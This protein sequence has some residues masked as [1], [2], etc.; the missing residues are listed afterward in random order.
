VDETVAAKSVITEYQDNEAESPASMSSV[1]GRTFPLVSVIIPVYNGE[2]YLA[3]A[4]D[5]ALAQT[6]PCV[7]VIVINDGSTDTSPKILEHYGQ[8]I[9]VFHQPNSGQATARNVG[10]SM[11]RG[12]WIAFLDQD[13]LWDP[14]KLSQQMSAVQEGD[15]VVYST[16]RTIDPHGRIVRR[17][18]HPRNESSLLLSD[19]IWRNPPAPLTVLVRR[20][21]INAVGGFDAGNRFGTDDYQLWLGLVAT[22]H[23]FRYLRRE[24]ASYR[25]HDS[26]MSKNTPLM[27]QGKVYALGQTAARYPAAFGRREKKALKRR[28][29]DI[30]LQLGIWH[31]RRGS[32]SQAAAAFGQ[33]VAKQPWQ[34]QAWT[35]LLLSS[36]PLRSRLVPAL[37]RIVAL[38]RP[39][40]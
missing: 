20:E 22:G 27:C 8:N 13:D 33:V 15:T 17:G 3:Q 21:A 26:N 9:R 14:D 39:V 10:V 28:L 24:L 31:L 7:E 11:A 19:L 4:L 37:R 29:A 5:S 6:Y 32:Y 36:M 1:N 23:R 40:V 16:A 12:T 18:I 2:R 38:T 34:I 30:D 35:M 25:V